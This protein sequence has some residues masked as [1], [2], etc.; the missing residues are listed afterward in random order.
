MSAVATT[1]GEL[2]AGDRVRF[3]AGDGLF[4]WVPVPRARSHAG[5]VEL[6]FADGENSEYKLLPRGTD[7]VRLSRVGEL[8]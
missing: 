8:A 3:P 4:A 1:A 5:S 2:R 7:L 6:L